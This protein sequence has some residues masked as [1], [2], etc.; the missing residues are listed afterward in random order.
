METLGNG[1]MAIWQGC[2]ASAAALADCQADV[3]VF[4]AILGLFAAVAVA[5]GIAACIAIARQ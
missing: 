5:G 3:F 2:H 1:M 4:K